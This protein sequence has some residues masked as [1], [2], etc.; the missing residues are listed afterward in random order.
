MRYQRGDVIEIPFSIPGRNRPENHPAI[1]I[2]NSDVHNNE[3][4]YICV[5]ITHSEIND[6]LAFP[7]SNDMFLNN[8]KAPDGKVK[9]HLIVSVSEKEIITN[10]RSKQ[11]RMRSVFVDKLVDFITEMVFLER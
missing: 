11:Q 2:S 7:L 4:L 6:F 1:I 3:D 5:M 9:A 8:E 10:S